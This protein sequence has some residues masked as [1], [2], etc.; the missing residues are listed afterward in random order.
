VLQFYFAFY[1]FFWEV[2]FRRHNGVADRRLQAWH[3]VTRRRW[4]FSDKTS[5]RIWSYDNARRLVGVY[6]QG[7]SRRARVTVPRRHR[8]LCIS[9][10]NRPSQPF[11]MRYH[12]VDCQ[13]SWWSWT[14]R[15]PLS[16][17]HRWPP[18]I[19]I[20]S[21]YSRSALVAQAA[22]QTAL[23]LHVSTPARNYRPIHG[24]SVPFCSAE[25][26]GWAAFLLAESPHLSTKCKGP[27]IR[28]TV[29]LRLY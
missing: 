18:D 5:A 6:I 15:R 25:S 2:V 23:T 1:L 11:T 17:W 21:I 12:I 19:A 26:P 29:G 3:C 24:W 28:G 27:P 9:T 20:R 22:S 14:P 8:T 10:G 7:R 4:I 13:E 16:M